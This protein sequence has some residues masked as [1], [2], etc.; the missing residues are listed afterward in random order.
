MA[1]TVIEESHSSSETICKKFSPTPEVAADF[2]A[3]SCD[4]DDIDESLFRH[5]LWRIALYYIYIELTPAQ[6]ESHSN[7]QRQV[8]EE[9]GLNGRIRISRE[10]VNGV[11]SGKHEILLD[12]EKKISCA[13]QG[14]L[15]SEEGVL[16]CAD[17]QNVVDDDKKVETIVNL[18]VKYCE[19]RTDLPIQKQLFDRLIVKKTLN[20]IGLFDQSIGQEQQRQ[21]QKLLKSERLRRRRERKRQEQEAKRQTKLESQDESQAQTQQIQ[22]PAPSPNEEKLTTKESDETYKNENNPSPF[23]SLDMSSLYKSVMK[24]PLKPA[25]HLT[26]TEWNKKL[27]AVTSSDKSALLLDVRNVYEMKVGHFVHPSTPTLLTNTRKYSDLPQML[28]SN[29]DMQERDQ[30]FMYC[31]GGVRCERVSMLVRE[32][33]PEK[34]IFQLHGGIQRYL[35]TCSE[36]SKQRTDQNN[37]GANSCTSNPGYFIGKNFVFDPRRTDPTHFGETVGRCLVCKNPHDDYDNGHAPSENKEARCNNCRMLILICNDCRPNY[38]CH[39]ETS[40][41]SEDSSRLLLYCNGDTCIHE[42]SMPDPEL[43][44][45]A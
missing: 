37:D 7:L 39:G 14:F 12:Y 17:N 22:S 25:Q 1:T 27:D 9:L 34:E 23:G 29:K 24:E 5:N 32:L 43:L 15:E 6:V 16:V 42:G 4:N 3:G 40:E 19:L 11:L 30:I 18:D 10:G 13:L 26:G 35:E 38:R 31:T 21:K 45:A 41:E 28:A 36:E 8:C 20:V 44:V 33:Y 2:D